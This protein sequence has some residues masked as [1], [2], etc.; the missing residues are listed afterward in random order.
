MKFK[1][2]SEYFEKLEKISSR[3]AL[4]DILSELFKKTPK[5]EIEKTIYLIQG[6]LAPFFVPIEIGMAEKT[7]AVS[8]ANAYDLTREEVLKLYQKLGDMGLASYELARNSKSVHST[9]SGRNSKLSVSEVFDVLNEIANTKGEGTVEK[10]QTLLSNLLKELDPISAKHLVRIPLGNTRLGIGD[11]TVL[12]ALATAKLGDKSNRKLLEGAYNRTSDLGLIAK[13]LWEKGLTG[14]EKLEVRVGSPIR[15]ELCER[16]PTP[17][18]VIEKMSLDSARDKIGVDVQYKYDGFR[19]VGGY[20]PIYTK[21]K[22]ITVMRDLQVGDEVLTKSGRFKKVLAKRKRMIRKKERLFV[23]K[24]YL[25]E[26]IKVSE[27][28]PVLALVDGKEQWKFIENIKSGDE[29]VFPLPIFPPSNPHPAPKKLE[30]QTIS[31]Y[32]KTFV[33]NEDFYRFMGFWIGDG[34]TNDFHNTERVGLT[35]NNRTEKK[36]ADEYE[37]IINTTL[38][39]SSISRN[40]HNGGLNLYWRDEPLKHWLSTYFR[41]EWQGK[42]LP[43][44]FSHVTKKQFMAFLTGWIESDGHTDKDGFTKI[45]TKERDLAAFAQLIALSFGIIMGLRYIRIKNKTYYSLLIPKT[46]RKARIIGQK[47]YVKVLRNA[48]FKNR[49][50]RTQLYDIQ[51]EDD[52]SFCIPMATLHNCQIHKN[53]DEIRMFSRNLE[54]MTHM[55]PELTVAARKQIK[56][57]NVILDTEA[58]AYNPESEE[59]LPFQETT[60]RR[61]KHNIL[62]MAEKLPLKA[63]VFDILYKD[64]KQLLDE[65]LYKRMEILKEV[66]SED[67]VLIRTKNQTVKD[68]KTL[69]ILLEDAISKGL[70]G[71]VVK[72]LESPYEAGGRNF[73]WV[74]LKRHSSGELNDT[75]DCVILGYITGK[76]KR[77]AFGAGALLVGVYDDKKDEFVTVS[78]I[79]TGLTDEEW[80]EVHKRADIIKLES[81]PARVNSQIIP[82]VWIKPEIVIEVL[83]DEITRSPIHTAGA[84]TSS[85]SHSGLSSSGLKTGEKEPGYALRFPRLVSFRNFDKKAEDSTS[86]K[87]L[88]DMYKQQ[89]L[90]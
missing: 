42:M 44:W 18:K 45:V 8:I 31:G 59:F 36:L 76:G 35:F 82:S 79:G 40:I 3:L 12:D 64:G 89:K 29:V 23:F 77:A 81:K 43:E 37:K 17:E 65:P 7:V 68:A 80:R 22:G 84:S 27:G 52:E 39:V 49:D 47:I 24:T 54:E 73:N 69:G 6:R 38:Q 48:E 62:E 88:I 1:E 74:K 78:K 30:L 26:E 50:E 71:L 21:R 86:V 10:R 5:E 16:L 56:A 53:G 57:E 34:F 75:I 60:K 46:Q 13:T 2:L 55:F 66:I 15:S 90:S 61:R 41:R 87:E 28:H 9:S 4:I 83:A 33:L 58:L 20:T 25:G 11:P 51:I 14:V 19:C 63:F 32:K 72:R 67:G 70:E 85:A